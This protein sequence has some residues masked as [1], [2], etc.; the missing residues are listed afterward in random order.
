MIPAIAIFITLLVLIERFALHRRGLAII[1]FFLFAVAGFR[2]NVLPLLLCGST[3]TGI[4]LLLVRQKLQGQRLLLIA[5]IAATAFVSTFHWIYSGDNL[6][7]EIMKFAPLNLSSTFTT[8]M[9]Q[10]APL[11]SAIA[12]VVPW[13]S[14]SV[15]LFLLL[16]VV[17]KQSVFAPVLPLLAC[18]SFSWLRARS[19][20][21]LFVWVAGFSVLVLFENRTNEQWAFYMFAHVAL[22]YL[23][24]HAAD[25]LLDKP[26]WRPRLRKILFATGIV[27]LSVQ[28][29][30]FAARGF[31]DV[32]KPFFMADAIQFDADLNALARDIDAHQWRGV[33]IPFQSDMQ[34]VRALTSLQ[35]GILLY[36]SRL[37][38]KYMEMA[39]LSPEMKRRIAF[40]RQVPSCAGLRNE[41]Q[42]FAR[43]GDLY[44]LFGHAKFVA[45]KGCSALLS[46]HG[47]WRLY[48]IN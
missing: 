28:V 4:M 14:L 31:A 12:S 3:A 13:Q 27:L 7:S 17:L 45:P 21:L 29:A 26:Q 33:A 35:R 10:S 43:D 2:A 15:G 1:T 38:I 22:T 44:L 46:H 11:Y 36:Y 24:A 8:P 39:G 48:R 37:G 47:K 30:W 41:A 25:A 6:S 23:V 5:L 16:I 34:D 19:L 18:R 40:A 9:L 20:L 42:R 32:R